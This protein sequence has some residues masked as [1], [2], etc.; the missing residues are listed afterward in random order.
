MAHSVQA[1]DG[2]PPVRAVSIQELEQHAR[3]VVRAVQE[4]GTAVDIVDEGLV[5][6]RMSP[7]AAPETRDADAAPAEAHRAWLALMDDVAR[8][9]A[10]DW[11]AGVSAQD[12]ID[13]I[14]RE[15]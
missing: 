12:V 2:G 14:R 13:D 3:E 7:S 11:P 9:L 1:K 4:T 8:D 10:A 6:A 5:V 15:L